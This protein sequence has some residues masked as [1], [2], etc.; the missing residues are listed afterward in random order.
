MIERRQP[1]YPSDALQAHEEGEVRLQI[2]IDPL[3]N[4]EDVRIAHSSGANSLDRAAMDA[5]RGW[6]YRPARRAGEAVSGAL[7]VPVQFSLD[8]R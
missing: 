1:E 3:G 6:R 7:E 2:S 8:E 4:V 5:A